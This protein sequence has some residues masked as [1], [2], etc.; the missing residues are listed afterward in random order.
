MHSP[1]FVACFS[2]SRRLGIKLT[3]WDAVDTIRIRIQ[4]YPGALVPP[5]KQLIPKPRLQNL[6]A[7]ESSPWLSREEQ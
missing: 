6:Y 4:T 7:G 1:S 5:L 3:D 2:L